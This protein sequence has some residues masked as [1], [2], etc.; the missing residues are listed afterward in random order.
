MGYIDPLG[1][2]IRD[3][4]VD[5]IDSPPSSSRKTYSKAFQFLTQFVRNEHDELVKFSH[6]SFI[7]PRYFLYRQ[8]KKLPH[9]LLKHLL[10]K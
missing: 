2:F 4:D 9:D 1:R 5:S 10:M 8:S 7:S 6:S 3:P